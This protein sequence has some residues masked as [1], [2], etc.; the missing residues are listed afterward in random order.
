MLSAINRVKTA[1]PALLCALVAP[2]LL[3]A[4]KTSV[5]KLDVRATCN[6]RG[7]TELA[8]SDACMRD[9]L[10]AKAELVK[11]WP[12]VPAGIRKSCLDEVNIGGSASYVELLTCSQMNE[13]SR[14]PPGPAA[15]GGPARRP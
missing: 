1:G 6:S 7:T 13:W 15:A 14:T 2:F 12:K 11:M 4:T 10:G 9:E 8:G 5:P 3:A